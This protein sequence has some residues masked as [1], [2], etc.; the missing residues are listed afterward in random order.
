MQESNATLPNIILMLEQTKTYLYTI[1]SDEG[2]N[3]TL[4]EAKSIAVDIDCDPS[5]PPLNNVRPRKKNDHLTMRVRMR[6]HKIR[7]TYLK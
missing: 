4:E 2:F 5:F 1:R 3:D 7:G 6:L